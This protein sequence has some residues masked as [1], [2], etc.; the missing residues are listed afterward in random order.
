MCFMRTLRPK[1]PVIYAADED[2]P[3]GGSKVVRSSDD[4]AVTIVGS[5][6]TVHEAMKAADNLRERACRC[7]S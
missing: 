3:I 4:D 5:G 1:T 2:F 7:A 6:I